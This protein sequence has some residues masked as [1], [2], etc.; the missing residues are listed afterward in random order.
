VPFAEDA[1]IVDAERIRGEV[2]RRV[3]GRE[4]SEVDSLT[5][6]IEVTKVMDVKS[7]TRL[8]IFIR[9]P[10]CSRLNLAGMK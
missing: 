9:C 7:K 3:I 5:D 10:R 2:R 8:F 1:A 4:K 6:A